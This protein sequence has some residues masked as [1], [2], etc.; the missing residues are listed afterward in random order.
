MVW[1]SVGL[2]KCVSD[3]SEN[4]IDVEFHDSS[5]HHTIHITNMNSYTM[6]DLSKE[7]LV[8]ARDTEGLFR[9][10]CFHQG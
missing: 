7:S 9:L 6:A 1:N 10:K 2:V 8:L 4:S 5:L 3:D